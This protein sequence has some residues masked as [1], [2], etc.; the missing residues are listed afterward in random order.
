MSQLLDD[1]RF[2]GFYHQSTSDAEGEGLGRHFDTPGRSVYAGFDPSRDSLTI[3][4][5]L[6]ILLLRR[7]QLAGHRP[8]VVMG[9][10]TGM[11]GDPSGK[12]SERPVLSKEQIA[13]NVERQ[14]RVMESLLSFEGATGAILLDNLS[15]LGPVSYL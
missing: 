4:N 2:R 9:G 13:S 11:I 6:Q 3:G 12:E 7:F 1:L 8:I 14:R 10:G 15:W 5:L